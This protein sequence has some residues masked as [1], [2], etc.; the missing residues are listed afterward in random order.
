MAYQLGGKSSLRKKDISRDFQVADQ[1]YFLKSPLFGLKF[2][3]D[4]SET[5]V[6]RMRTK[7]KSVF[8]NLSFSE[9]SHFCHFIFEKF[10]RKVTS[11]NRRRRCCCR[12]QCRRHR[13]RRNSSSSSSSSN[14]RRSS[15]IIGR[16]KNSV[17]TRFA[18]L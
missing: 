9:R 14:R 6:L 4:F 12:R 11:T 15:S 7:Y 13:R 18:G 10:E 17:D 3:F 5:G 16:V 8:F 2:F 1:K